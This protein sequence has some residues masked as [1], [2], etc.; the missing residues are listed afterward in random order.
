MSEKT[1]RERALEK[2]AQ[3]LEE[4]QRQKT[5]ARSDPLKAAAEKRK[6]EG[7]TPS[8]ES[9]ENKRIGGRDSRMGQMMLYERVKRL[10]AALME[11]G[12]S[13]QEVRAM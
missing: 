7:I 8:E 4:E 3:Q 13:W 5:K 10:E 2:L 11:L 6:A 12:Y 9:R 1:L